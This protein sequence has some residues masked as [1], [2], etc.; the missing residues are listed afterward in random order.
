[1]SRGWMYAACLLWLQ[2]LDVSGS[3]ALGALPLP[4]I[5]EQTL[6]ATGA[7][8]RGAQGAQETPILRDEEHPL[9]T[10]METQP[11]SMSLLIKPRNYHPDTLVR[12]LYERVSKQK[13]PI[14]QHL[15]DPVIV[16]IPL[17]RTAQKHELVEL[18][19]GKYIVC[20]EAMLHGEVYQTSCF[21]TIIQRLDTNTLQSGVK[22][23]IILS[24]V[25][26]AAVIVYAIGYRIL[27][28]RTINKKKELDALAI[29]KI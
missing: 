6:G 17:I 15:D 11:H 8:Q 23:L 25:L 22:V 9:V 29:T 27:K 3:A 13:R 16:Y 18:P 14:M 19:M 4:N 12:L 5:T 26:V 21:E 20:G 28:I 7:T 2:L 1:M 24:L 10:V